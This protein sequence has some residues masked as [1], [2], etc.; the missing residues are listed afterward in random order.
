MTKAKDRVRLS[1]IV[2]L[3]CGD[4]QM[5]ETRVKP[6]VDSGEPLFHCM[7]F[8]WFTFLQES[9]GRRY[10]NVL[11]QLVIE[12]AVSTR[13]SVC[14]S[15]TCLLCLSS[16]FLKVE[17]PPALLIIIHCEERRTSTY[18]GNLFGALLN[19]LSSYSP[20]LPWNP[21]R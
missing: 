13:L 7:K 18:K 11:L 21:A 6:S 4:L 15:P 20:Y 9:R 1:D 8:E 19:A 10:E 3:V 12:K 17:S 14:L 16:A 2:T 5:R